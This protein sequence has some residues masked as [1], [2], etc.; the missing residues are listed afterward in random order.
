[1]FSA[2]PLALPVAALILGLLVGSFLN[3]V[4]YRLPI[5][6]QLAWRAQCDEIAHEPPGTT[7]P[8]GPFNLWGPRS[9][10]PQ[11]GTP[12]AA[13]H[14]VPVLSY[15]WLKGRCAHCRTAI[16]KRY[17]LL[18]GFTA[19]L[20]LIVALRFGFGWETALALP[21]T[22]ALIALAAIDLEHQLLPDAITLPLLW[23]G[24]A[25]SLLP[26]PDAAPLFASLEASVL[27]AM[28]GYLCLWSV[29]QLFKLVTGKEG[30]GYGDFKLLAALGAWMGW[31][32]LP[33]IIIVSAGVGAIV[34]GLALA[35]SG[36]SRATP[37]PF[38]PFLAAAGWI[39]LLWGS[40]LTGLYLSWAG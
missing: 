14:N 17:P 32:A 39:A 10:C 5:M 24:I 13:R 27:G 19:I 15:L 3:V 38:G 20:S 33:L 12:I 40:E 22:W 29:Y 31:Q 11:C 7:V 37:I 2:W 1:M 21:F 4:A 25:V 28:A 36:R 26:T 18:E 34:G 16:S 6:L 23:V 30:M 9:A 35:A 8:V